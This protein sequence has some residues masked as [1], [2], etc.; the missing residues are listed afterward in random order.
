MKK[1][2]T[3]LL[4][5]S[6]LVLS[7][8]IGHADAAVRPCSSEILWNVTAILSSAGNVTF[9]ATTQYRTT[10][11]VNSCILQKK[12]GN[13][14]VF[15]QTLMCPAGISNTT[16]YKKSM[17]YSSNLTSGNIYRVIAVFAADGETRT[18]TSDGITY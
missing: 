15:D 4:V 16:R 2:I 12:L 10:I 11:K 18:A 7:I 5:I 9:T 17:D 1:T 8:G 14:W 3:M 6:I 13:T